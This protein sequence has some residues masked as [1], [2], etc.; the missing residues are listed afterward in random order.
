MFYGYFPILQSICWIMKDGIGKN[1]CVFIIYIELSMTI[2]LG[3][4][5]NNLT[6]LFHVRP[7]HVGYAYS[8]SKKSMDTLD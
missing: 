5:K 7:A 1:L 6:D 8:E 3:G 4:A 2:N